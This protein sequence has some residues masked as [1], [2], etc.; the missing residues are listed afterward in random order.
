MR[1]DAVPRAPG[2]VPDQR[3]EE[4]LATRTC[5][6]ATCGGPRYCLHRHVRSLSRRAIEHWRH[7]VSPSP[8][9]PAHNDV[10]GGKQAVHRLLDDRVP[11]SEWARCG[12][13]AERLA[14][15]GFTVADVVGHHSF[16]LEDVVAG[17]Q[18]D[19]ER[20]ES[21]HFHPALL[22][23][24][25]EFPTIVF[26]DEPVSLTA[27]R[28]M[29]SFPLGFRQMVAEWHLGALELAALRFDARTLHA[30]GMSAPLLTRWL[31]V[32]ATV[33]AKGVLWWIETF[34]YTQALHRKIFAGQ[35]ARMLDMESKA[36]YSQLALYTQPVGERPTGL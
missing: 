19:W 8:L 20:L 3:T 6:A 31:Q 7:Y 32:D 10:D 17:L 28:L 23:R 5:H 35:T 15:L 26:V 12:V 4:A 21:M 30:I 33:D 24:N 14:A 27:T 22:A 13:D 25:Q 18:L 11:P 16:L 36:V 29:R 9:L 2:G 1:V 34:A